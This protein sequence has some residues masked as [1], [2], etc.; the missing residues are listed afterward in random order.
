MAL[1]LLTLAFLL[2]LYPFQ[3]LPVFP[4]SNR[5]TKL[6]ENSLCMVMTNFAQDTFDLPVQFESAG[7]TAHLF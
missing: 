3:S 4:G 2:P 6:N 7:N 5:R 1:L